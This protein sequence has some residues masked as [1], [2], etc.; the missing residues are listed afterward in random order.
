MKYNASMTVDGRKVKLREEGELKTI[1]GK[2]PYQLIPPESMEAFARAMEYGA[3]KH[4]P[5]DWRKGNGMPWTWLLAAILRHTWALMCGED[6]DPSSNLHHGAHIMAGAS[7]LIYYHV[8]RKT[9][10]KDDRFIV[11]GK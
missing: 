3:I 6:I 5:D 10:N 2:T 1:E 11:K 7:M 4:E 9:F 8:H